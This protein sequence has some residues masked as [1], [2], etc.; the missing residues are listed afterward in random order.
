M[1]TARSLK[2]TML[3]LLLLAVAAPTFVTA[4]TAKPAAAKASAPAKPAATTA[5]KPA[6][7]KK[8]PPTKSRVEAKS[9]AS[10]MAA[11]I[12]AAEA[13]LTPGELQIAER[14]HTGVMP[15]ELGTSVL[16]EPDPKS[17]GYFN[18]TTR[19]LK[20]RMFPVPT[21]TGAVRLED[22]RAGAVWI[23]LG[24]KSMLLNQAAGQRL[25]DECMSPQQVAFAESMKGKP[26]QNVLEPAPVVV[27]PA[28]AAPAPAAAAAAQSAAT[29]AV[30]AASTATAAASA[31][32]AAASA[33]TAAASAAAPAASAPARR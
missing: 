9:T 6:A 31:A 11:G 25:A 20:Y 17:P 28:A 21:S 15:C 2:T 29:A 3:P 16:I 23:Q 27:A 1:K 7:A 24:N 5:A 12:Q 32:T 10:N 30:A 18:V 8:A 14:V 33:A 19:K 4:Q 22:Q 13:A 26:A